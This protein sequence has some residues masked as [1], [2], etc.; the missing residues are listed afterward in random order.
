MEDFETEATRYIMQIRTNVQNNNTLSLEAIDA[1][2][3][4]CLY[5]IKE[6]K[7]LERQLDY[8]LETGGKY[9]NI[10]AIVS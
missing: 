6:I 10:D 5:Q 9:L 4:S 2:L 8:A 1:I 3:G 7:K